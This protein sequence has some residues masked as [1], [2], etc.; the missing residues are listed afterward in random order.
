MTPLETTSA[1]A[2]GT[3]T[4]ASTD[5]G[6][7]QA[8]ALNSAA[9]EP[10][11]SGAAATEAAPAASGEEEDLSTA[12]DYEE[13]TP[14]RDNSVGSSPINERSPMRSQSKSPSSLFRAHR[15][16]LDDYAIAQA[17]ARW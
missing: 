1:A 11:V 17:T 8:V 12:V 4:T 7:T 5:A 15:C 9:A 16:A 13:S 3:T 10:S 6:G 14:E 2:R